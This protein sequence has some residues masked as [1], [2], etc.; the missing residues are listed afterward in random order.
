MSIETLVVT[1]GHFPLFIIQSAHHR[2][3]AKKKVIIQSAHHHHHRTA[4]KKKVIIQSAHHHHHRHG[5]NIDGV[6]V[7][8]VV[9]HHL[10][11]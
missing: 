10:G 2:T 4:A 3:A 1:C 9:G 6:P 7:H 11:E 5:P 8:R